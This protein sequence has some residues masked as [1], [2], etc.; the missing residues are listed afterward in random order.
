MIKGNNFG[1]C[2]ATNKGSRFD[3]CTSFDYGD[4]VGMVLSVPG[5]KLPTATF[6]EATYTKLI[7][8]GLAFP[9]LGTFG[10]EQTTPENETTTDSQGNIY[11]VRVAK[12]QGTFT[13]QANEC[14]VR[15]LQDK[16]GKAWD[17]TFVTSKGAR[18][19]IDASNENV[20]GFFSR[21]VS[22]G[23]FM[24]K[25]GTDLQRVMVTYQ[26]ADAEDWNNSAVF[27]SNQEAG[28]DFK[29]I[30]GAYQADLKVVAT[31]GTTVEVT[32][33]SVCNSSLIYNGLD[34][35][36]F[37]KVNGVAPSAVT[38]NPSTGK[39]TLTVTTT[40]AGSN[41]NVTL[42]AKDALGNVYRGSANVVVGA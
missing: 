23:S 8:D 26:L 3:N 37:W 22:V 36:T 16:A 25:A 1:D 38:Q 15:S 12:A 4:V 34:T 41:L 31:A 17:I 24:F 29:D 42:N 18:M 33:I 32:P 10:F 14:V 9:Y 11:E 19:K 28:F 35:M 30:Q 6:T 40:T 13:F 5:T 7:E 21:Y 27:V 39:Y 20:L 2:F